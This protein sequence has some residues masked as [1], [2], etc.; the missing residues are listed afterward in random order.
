MTV[1]TG[2]AAMSFAS[3]AS[4]ST[5]LSS[6]TSGSVNYTDSASSD[7]SSKESKRG[8]INPLKKKE[9]T[10]ALN[11]DSRFRDN[12]YNTTS[13]D[14]NIRLPMSFEKI[15]QMELMNIELPLSF[16]GVTK[17]KGNNYF[18]LKVTKIIGGTTY[19]NYFQI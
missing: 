10:K 3:T 11:I 4:I 16:Y 6:A 9:V 7:T 13:T 19:Y 14:Y 1:P 17:E 18:W 12:Y 15:V 8:F 5:G 2:G